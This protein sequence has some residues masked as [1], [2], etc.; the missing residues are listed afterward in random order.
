MWNF[1]NSWVS[2]SP[3]FRLPL[4]RNVISGWFA[5]GYLKMQMNLTEIISDSA[6]RRSLWR[7][8]PVALDETSDFQRHSF[9]VAFK[10]TA[11]SVRSHI[12][13]FDIFEN[14]RTW[15]SEPEPEPEPRSRYILPGAGAGAGAAKQ[16]YSEPEPEP[17]AGL[18]PRSRSHHGS[19]SNF[20]EC[21][22]LKNN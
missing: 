18:L 12:L 21:N 20:F 14:M 10:L 8:Q 3:L 15:S 2:P 6:T 1:F 5:F 4:T 9:K 11:K 17:W 13:T 16:F 22:E 7:I 19:A